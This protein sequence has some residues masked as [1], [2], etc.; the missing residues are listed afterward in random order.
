MP[1][2]IAGNGAIWVGLE[3]TYGTPV[4]PT[5]AG[6][7]VWVPIISESLS[8]TEDKYYSPQIRQSAIVSDVKQSYY[9]TEG[10]IVIE[11]D[12]TFLPY[13]LYAS[14]HSIAKS[15][16]GP[17]VLCSYSYQRRCYLSRRFCQRYEYLYSP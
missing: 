3:T 17:Y 10:D 15:G 1:A 2:D 13:F 8:Y 4:D 5:A 12:P 7:G 16:S 14:R 6:V 11:A 9:H